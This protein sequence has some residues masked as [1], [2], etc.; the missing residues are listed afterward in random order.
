MNTLEDVVKGC[1]E[2]FKIKNDN[3]YL[4]FL[5]RQ[6]TRERSRNWSYDL[7]FIDTGINK[8]HYFHMMVCKL[9]LFSYLSGITGIRAGY[10][11]DLEKG[12]KAK[13]VNRRIKS[14]NDLYLLRPAEFMGATKNNISPEERKRIKEMRQTDK[15]LCKLYNIFTSRAYKKETVWQKWG[16]VIDEL[17]HDDFLHNYFGVRISYSMVKRCP[18]PYISDHGGKRH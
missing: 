13:K 14:V 2:E 16:E 9:M 5:K 10:N 7:D 11:A 1:K 8:P 6:E 17:G 15:R 18:S 4:P 12:I 3:I